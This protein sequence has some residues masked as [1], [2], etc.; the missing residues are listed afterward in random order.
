M[1]LTCEDSVRPEF[2]KQNQL[3]GRILQTSFLRPY[4]LAWKMFGYKPEDFLEGA[5]EQT[6][7]TTVGDDAKKVENQLYT[8]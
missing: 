5:I 3:R 2:G 6:E 4:S 7:T 8:R 1:C